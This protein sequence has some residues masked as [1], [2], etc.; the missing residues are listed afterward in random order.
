MALS[1]KVMLVICDVSAQLLKSG[2]LS[3]TFAFCRLN[4]CTVN[5]LVP[6]NPL[7]TPLPGS[8]ACTRQK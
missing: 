6:K 5:G 4:S 3:Q 1:V 7:V 8:V 2:G